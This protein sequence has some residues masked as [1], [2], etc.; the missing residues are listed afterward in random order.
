M[1]TPLLSPPDYGQGLFLYLTAFESTIG[2]VLVQEDN[3]Q[4]EH[5]IYYL[6]KGLVGPRA[7]I[8]TC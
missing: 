2:M 7:S 3:A 1:S 6:R 4:K 8:F 5:V